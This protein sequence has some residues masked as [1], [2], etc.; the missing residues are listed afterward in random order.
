MRKGRYPGG[1]KS[2][3]YDKKAWN[4]GASDERVDELWQC[5]EEGKREKSR[6]EEGRGGG[7]V[8]R[9]GESEGRCV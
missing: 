9:R 5:Q 2:L 3:I 1:P 7:S 4:G 6:G 8:S